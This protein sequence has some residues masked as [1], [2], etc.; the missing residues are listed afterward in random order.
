MIYKGEIVVAI[1]PDLRDM[2]ECE[3]VRADEENK[4]HLLCRI[5]S[6]VQYPIQ[7]AILDG[8][9]PNENPPIAQGAVCRLKFVR[10]V[11]TPDKHIQNYETS[12]SRCLAAYERRR[13]GLYQSLEGVPEALSRGIRRP[14]PREFDILERHK[15]KEYRSRRI[16]INH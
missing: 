6:M 10:R 16:I 2:Y 13:R 9:V 8:S 4:M 3:V 15:N 7:H 5:L 12:V 1:D 14:D 11:E